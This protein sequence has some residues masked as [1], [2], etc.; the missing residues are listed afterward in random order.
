MIEFSLSPS[1]RKAL[2][3]TLLVDGSAFVIRPGFRTI[4]KILR[5]LDDPGVIDR[6]KGSL[7]CDWFFVD[8]PPQRWEEIFGWFLRCGD[9]PELSDEMP[10]FDYEFDAP[11][12]YASFLQLYG[13]D[14]FGGDLHWWAFRALLEGAFRSR[15]PLAEKLRVRTLDVSKCEDKAAAQAAKD[16]V[17]IPTRLSEG[18]RIITEKI[19]ERLLRGEPVAD[20]IGG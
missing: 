18:E 17:Q 13:V 19:T 11:E 6:H 4:L 12:I 9:P 3:D 16:R 8:A 5:M 10:V 14:L 1:P 20:L 15:C 7:L 2:P